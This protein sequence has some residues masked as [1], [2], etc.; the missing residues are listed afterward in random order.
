MYTSCRNSQEGCVTPNLDFKITIGLFFIIFIGIWYI[1][2]CHFQWPWSFSMT[3]NDFWRSFQ[4]LQTISL[5][6]SQNTAYTMYEVNY[7]SRTSH[8]SNYF[9]CRIRPEGLLCDAE[10]DLLAIAKFLFTC[11]PITVF[12]VFLGSLR[13]N[14]IRKFL[15]WGCGLLTFYNEYNVC[16]PRETWAVQ[17]NLNNIP[18]GPK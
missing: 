8:V 4:V 3:L 10:R 17:N 7:N 1:E 16:V 15:C 9:Y 6:V 2:W 13:Q 18:G 12:N 5:S 11:R 14:R